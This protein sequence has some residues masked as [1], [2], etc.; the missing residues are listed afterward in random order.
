MRGLLGMLLCCGLAL[1]AGAWQEPAA[2]NTAIRAS[3]AGGSDLLT[4]DEEDPVP[5]EESAPSV[6]DE[7]PT[8]TA[9]PAPAEDAPSVE[10][11]PT[12]SEPVPAAEEEAPSIEET[13][14]PAPAGDAPSAEEA[15]GVELPPAPVEPAPAED[16]LQE[17][18]QNQQ[19]AFL[20][21]AELVDSDGHYQAGDTMKLRVRSEVD[22][23]LYVLFKQADGTAFQIFPN[24]GQPDNRVAAKETIQIPAQDDL[25]RWVIG[26]PFGTE[27]VKVIASKTPIKEL[28]N[29]ALRS[30]RF[31]RLSTS[32][33]VHA[34]RQL[35]HQRSATWAEVDLQIETHEK[36]DTPGGPGARRWGVFFGVSKYKYHHYR[37]EAT[38]GE[39]SMDLMGC[40]NDATALGKVFTEAGRLSGCKVFVDDQATKH[41]LGE[42][43]TKWLP[44]VSR[45]G[46]T[47]IISF[48]GHGGQI[49][50]DNGDEADGYDEFLCTHDFLPTDVFIEMI[51][52]QKAGTLE[53]ADNRFLTQL[54][55]RLP[56][57]LS[58]EQYF[59]LLSR[60][61]SVS[62][63]LF[64]RWLQNLQGRQIL[65]ILDTCHSGGFAVDTKDFQAKEE[66]MKFNFLD[67]ETARLK[68]I[69]QKEQ[70]LLAA[71]KSDQSAFE[72]LPE[73]TFGLMTYF[74]LRSIVNL[75]GPLDLDR[76]YE[77]LSGEMEAWFN[78]FNQEL[79]DEGSEE[80]LPAH[81]P[82]MKNYCSQPF[83]L[84]PKPS[85]G[86]TPAN[87]G[88]SGNSPRR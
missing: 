54:L 76:A 86:V 34:T 63:D 21:H 31:N 1:P 59:S 66:A 51:N 71:A 23:Y 35:K 50:D 82:H 9:D 30:A 11:T 5:S 12:P 52:R 72:L 65:L 6:A 37:H 78:K 79:A 87:P 32:T 28:S 80:R 2:R 88:R 3:A 36:S 85:S 15:P 46:D 38:N 68:D 20:V 61:T 25:F 43:I 18:I 29:P 70:A 44:S 60:E 4:A 53:Q 19:P 45:P 81:Q 24:S 7:A 57:N 33:I 83:I 64:T 56:R 73:R 47:V 17:N 16:D 13:L 48:S 42:A 77:H 58:D 26:P 69:G 10:E 75:E 40:A 27:F 8:E 39:E 67:D 74:L 49:I 84:K 62:D 41:N 55:G 14:P 22:A